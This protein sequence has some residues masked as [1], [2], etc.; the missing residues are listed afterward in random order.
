ML[1]RSRVLIADKDDGL[2]SS[3][4]LSDRIQIPTKRRLT[5]AGQMHVPCTFARTGI[6]LYTAAQLNL[7]GVPPKTVIEVHR[8][9]GEVFNQ[10]SMDS[11]KSSPLTLGHPK[12]SDGKP[13]AVTAENSKEFQVGML[14]GLPKR[15]EDS[16]GG[17]LVL[18]SQKAIDSLIDGTQE[19]SA[20][21]ACDIKLIDGAYHQTN[22]R[23]N[24]IAIVDKGRAGP[25][26]RISDEALEVQDEEFLEVKTKLLAD[27][28]IDLK[29]GYDEKELAKSFYEALVKNKSDLELKDKQLRDS[30]LLVATGVVSIDEMKLS[31][32]K[33]QITLDQA[34]IAAKEGVVAR[35]EAIENA[36]LVADMRDLGDKT[37]EQ[38]HRMVVEDQMPDKKLENKSEAYIEAMF[39][40]L[41]D[42]AKG[43]TPMSKI[44][45]D[46]ATHIT[47]D[48]EYVN[49]VLEARD[50]MI[51]ANKTS[52]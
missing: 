12:G 17:E 49:P 50:R 14:E 18:T 13:I 48:S 16:L 3:I 7:T 30:E 41:V 15:F 10:D 33:M 28:N 9:E 46:Q 2:L 6:Q 20:C 40:I 31:M 26:C 4:K 23:A 8:S 37:I 43:E 44:L 51:A 39:E 52:T 47:I 5:D 35:C 36:R 11:F 38:I 24:H 45:K 22:I 29:T 25:N 34:L 21:Y 32:S 19:L 27:Y 1:H 42:T